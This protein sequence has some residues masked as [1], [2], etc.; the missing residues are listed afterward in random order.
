MSCWSRARARP[1]SRCTRPA[2]WTPWSAG[3]SSST[4][5]WP[6]AGTAI[7]AALRLGAA[8]GQRALERGGAPRLAADGR[9]RLAP[10]HPRPLAVH[11]HRPDLGV[12]PPWGRVPYHY[13]TWDYARATAGCG[14]RAALLPRPRLLVLG[15]RARRLGARRLLQRHYAAGNSGIRFGVQGWVGG[16]WGLFADWVVCPTRYFGNRTDRYVHDGRY[17][18][19]RYRGHG[20]PRGILTTDTWGLTR[21][22]G[23]TGATRSACC[24][25]GPAAAARRRRGRGAAGRHAVRRPQSGPVGRRRWRRGAG[26]RRRRGPVVHRRHRSTRSSRAARAAVAPAR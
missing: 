15:P 26:R 7:R 3:A 23:A 6:T 13:G 19:R 8:G 1:A 20:L 22:A 21:I 16:D 2:P 11:L 24:A 12:R 25:P 9:H 18:G 5:R 10:L 14:S 4:P 17:W